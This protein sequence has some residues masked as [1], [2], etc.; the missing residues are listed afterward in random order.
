MD[1]SVAG[2]GT[3]GSISGVGRYLKEQKP[4]VTVVAADPE[5]SVLSGDSPRPW[6]VEGIGDDDA[7]HD[8]RG[9]PDC[10]RNHRSTR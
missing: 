7:R 5:G 9:G 10:A 1:V 2:V 6:K 4:E 8:P 3:G